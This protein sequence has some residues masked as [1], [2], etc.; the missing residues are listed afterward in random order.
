MTP[1]IRGRLETRAALIPTVGLV[2]SILFLPVVWRGDG[3]FVDHLLALFA[4][5]GLLLVPG[6]AWEFPYHAIQQSRWD[7]DWPLSIMLLAAAG[8]L[9][10]ATWISTKVGASP[11]NALEAGF[12]LGSVWIGCCLVAAGPIKVTVPRMR[13]RGGRL[14]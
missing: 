14:V 8:E 7:R 2:I 5:L 4:G 6:L 12:H 9:V 3:S 10:L 13:Y 11:L 1:S